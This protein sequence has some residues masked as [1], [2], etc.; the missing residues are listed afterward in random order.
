MFSIFLNKLPVQT[1][2]RTFIWG[3]YFSIPEGG[4]REIRISELLMYVYKAVSFIWKSGKS[5]SYAKNILTTVLMSSR[6]NAPL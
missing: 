4:A 2:A 1:S 5:S 6:L 3:M